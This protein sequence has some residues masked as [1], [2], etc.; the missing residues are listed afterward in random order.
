MERIGTVSSGQPVRF[1]SCHYGKPQYVSVDA[2]NVVTL[3][4]P[5]KRKIKSHRLYDGGCNGGNILSTE[6]AKYRPYVLVL[7][8]YSEIKC[9]DL[10]RGDGFSF[11]P[12]EAAT[13]CALIRLPFSEYNFS[14]HTIDTNVGLYVVIGYWYGKIELMHLVDIYR[15]R[16][17]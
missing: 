17:L 1:L 15:K 13:T 16:L 5:G 4:I 12:N 10:K 7:L 9:W 3:N 6:F 11:I 14:T 8:N 2:D